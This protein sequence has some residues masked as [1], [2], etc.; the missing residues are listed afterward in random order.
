MAAA[1]ALHAGAELRGGARR[2]RRKQV[3]GGRGPEVGKWATRVVN[4]S[5][6]AG[7]GQPQA[8][9][10]PRCRSAQVLGRRAEVR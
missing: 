4:A 9:S 5:Y 1:A 6:R 8:R 3:R 7:P 2:P 10:G